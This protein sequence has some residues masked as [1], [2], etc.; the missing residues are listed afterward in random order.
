MVN[1]ERGGC[2]FSKETRKRNIF[3]KQKSGFLVIGYWVAL[4]RA[5]FYK[6]GRQPV[7]NLSSFTSDPPS[8]LNVFGHD[9][10]PLGVDSA[11]VGVFKETD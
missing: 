7:S 5:V 9:G 11:Q 1:M 6:V 10:D 4:K 3:I 2:R 8:Q